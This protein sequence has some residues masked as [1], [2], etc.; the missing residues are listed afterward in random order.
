LHDTAIDPPLLRVNILKIPGTERPEKKSLWVKGGVPGN[1]PSS[2]GYSA[3]TFA[4]SL[5][6]PKFHF[7]HYYNYRIDDA[8]FVISPAMKRYFFSRYKTS[9]ILVLCLLISIFTSAQKGKGEN[10]VKQKRS[11]LS[12]RILIINPGSTT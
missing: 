11:A 9:V 5:T 2:F 7:A 6:K 10:A 1:L 12:L 3:L 4:T 8:K